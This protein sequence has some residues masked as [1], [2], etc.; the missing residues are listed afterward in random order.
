MHVNPESV[1]TQ[2]P[3]TWVLRQQTLFMKHSYKIYIEVFVIC[4]KT[5]MLQCNSYNYVINLTTLYNNV[6][7]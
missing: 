2:F 1:I 3:V 5:L 7:R 4:N 6:H